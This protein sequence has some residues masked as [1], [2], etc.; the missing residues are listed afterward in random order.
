MTNSQSEGN[1]KDWPK[2][3]RTI[4]PHARSEIVDGLSQ[5]MPTV[6]KRAGLTTP[7]RLAHFLAQ[8][9]EESAEFRAL[10]EY[11]DGR[12]Y[13]H[14]RDLG[15]V[16]IGDG[17]R[18]KGRGLIQ[19]TG[20]GNYAAASKFF[21]VDFIAHPELFEV[22]PYAALSAAFFWGTHE[23]NAL[24]DADDVHGITRRINGG[25]NG[26]EARIRYLRSAKAALGVSK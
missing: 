22:F 26:I 4:A 7:L 18:F 8:T 1:P 14:R 23:L 24:A 5:A 21:A 12:E 13:E 16:K 20:R 2:I 6:I 15:N 11:G 3:L 17:P 10:R 19:I 9:A 25:L